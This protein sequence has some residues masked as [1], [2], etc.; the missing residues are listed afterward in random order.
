[1]QRIPSV[2]RCI[3]VLAV[4]LL[5]GCD[6]GTIAAGPGGGTLPLPEGYWYLNTANDSGLP[7]VISERIVGVALERTIL[8]SAVLNV[9]DDGRWTQRYW[10]RVFVTGLLD[11]TEVVIDEGTW[12]QAPAGSPDNTY[13]LTSTVRARTAEVSFAPPAT[14]LRTI[15]PMLFFSGAPSVEGAYRRTRP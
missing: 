9:I 10:Y 12:A 4:A 3:A 2:R 8:D 7:S 11:R 13:V 15:E 5:A 14:E 6:E 1:M